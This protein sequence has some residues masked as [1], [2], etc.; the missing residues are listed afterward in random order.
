MT[1]DHVTSLAARI[2]CCTCHTAFAALH[3]S[4][5]SCLI[6]AALLLRHLRPIFASRLQPPRNSQLLL[7]LSL[8]LSLLLMELL[9][10]LVEPALLRVTAPLADSTILYCCCQPNTTTAT[11][12]L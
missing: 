5:S 10:I 8:S 2:A 3:E 9:L 1:A 12:S 6:V 11:G 7:S 4:C